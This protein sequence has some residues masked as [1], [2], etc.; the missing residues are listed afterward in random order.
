M[1]AKPKFCLICYYARMHKDICGVYCK[2]GK[3]EHFRDLRNTNGKA[4]RA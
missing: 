2:G 4:V 3:C 1:T